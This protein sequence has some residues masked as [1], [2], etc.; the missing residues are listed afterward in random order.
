MMGF[1]ALSPSYITFITSPNDGNLN[2]PNEFP[3]FDINGSPLLLE[4]AVMDM[5]TK[6]ALDSENN[7][8]MP[9]FFNFPM[10]FAAPSK[11]WGVGIKF[12]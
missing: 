9:Y 4:N 6:A 2:P 7:F 8:G 12:N 3:D 1:V 5:G 11:R 10:Y